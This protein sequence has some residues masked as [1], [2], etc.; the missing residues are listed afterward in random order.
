MNKKWYIL[1]VGVLFIIAGVIMAT[2]KIYPVAIV[3]GSFVWY[4]IWNKLE[5]ATEHA[6]IV[7]LTASKTKLPA[8]NEVALIIKKDTLA[9]LIE[10]VI[11]TRKGK[12]EFVNFESRSQDHIDRLISDKGKMGKAATFMYGLDAEAFNDLVL[13]PQSRREVAQEDLEKQH[14]SFDDWFLQAKKEARVYLFFTPLTW[15]GQYVK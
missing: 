10:D 11:L 15:D 13:M 9:T 12:K 3:N 2:N 14:I 4:R 8:D 5:R 7:E 6:L 1:I